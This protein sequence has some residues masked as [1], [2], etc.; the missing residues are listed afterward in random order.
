MS[1]FL[2]KKNITYI[3]F[4]LIIFSF[5]LGFYYDENSAGAGGYK[6][7]ITWILNNIE[8]F[9]NNKLKDAILSD[10]L[11]GNRTP[12]VYIINNFLNPFFYEYEKY[13]LTTFLI[14]LFGPI[15]IYFCLKNR[16]PKTNKEL[17]V[18][19]SSLILLS[20]YYRT[21]AYWALNENYGLITSLISLLFLNL[22]LENIKIKQRGIF[23]FITILFSSLSVYFDL[24]LLI[25][26]MIC[27]FYLINARIEV[28][29]KSY[30]FLMYL[31]L[32]LPYLFLIL[33]WNGI[34][35]PKTQAANVNTAT[36]LSRL[37]DLHIYH[38]GYVSTIIGFYLF[39]F[40]FLKEKNFFEIIYNFFRVKWN[41]FILM[42]SLVYI[43]YVYLNIE[44][45]SYTVDE[46]W[47]GLGVVNKIANILF[48]D[49]DKKEIFTYLMFF[50]SW[51]VICLYVENLIDFII[52]SFFF[53]ISLLL[54]PL[55]QEYFDPIIVILC[56]MIFKTRMKL[57]YYNIYFLFL[58]YGIFLSI[59]NIYYKNLI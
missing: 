41:I 46:Y 27:F 36:N 14:S 50:L 38:L 33:E 56:L 22:Y 12:L 10:D 30:T 17:I 7:D 57:D 24:K 21:S 39:P 52:L 47:I 49:I 16:Y 15:F 35:P 6:G 45:K 31:V 8:I 18:L 37:G 53:I 48:N 19:L 40:L 2:T 26:P 20:P 28:K 51:T 11:F 54:W 44:F 59:A 5:F 43:L 4:S 34:V 55:M 9:K 58:Y 13:R 29:L 32:G 3:I 23:L 1:K 42:I 25:V